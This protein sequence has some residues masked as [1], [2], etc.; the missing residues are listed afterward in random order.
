MN[1]AC[2]P[3]SHHLLHGLRRLFLDRVG[4]HESLPAPAHPSWTG[5]RVG[6]LGQVAYALPGI[7]ELDPLSLP[8]PR[9]VSQSR[10]EV[11]PRHR[12]GFLREEAAGG[13]QPNVTEQ[14]GPE[15]MSHKITF[16]TLGAKAA[17]HDV[18]RVLDIPRRSRHDYQAHSV[19]AQHDDRTGAR[20]RAEI[21]CLVCLAPFGRQPAIGRGS[22]EGLARHASLPCSG[23]G[24]LQYPLLET[25]PL[26]RRA[27]TFVT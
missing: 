12:Y 3:N 21:K 15:T 27:T 9:T 23:T 7:T 16:G 18:G 17:I 2:G 20:R 26:P 4:H 6:C 11:S 1:D 10:I 24:H 13:D 14:Y 19:S 5:T 25:V 8:P 22:L